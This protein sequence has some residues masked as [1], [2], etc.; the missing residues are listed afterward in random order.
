MIDALWYLV[1]HGVVFAIGTAI[2]STNAGERMVWT[3]MAITVVAGPL[4]AQ[5]SKLARKLT[6]DKHA[7][8]IELDDFRYAWL[9]STIWFGGALIAAWALADQIFFTSRIEM[10]ILALATAAMLV[11]GWFARIA[12]RKKAY[13]R[14]DVAAGVVES[15]DSTT[16]A[17]P[18]AELGTFAIETYRRPN[19]GRGHN[20]DW[21]R[22]VVP[23]F[24]KR[25]FADS[26]YPGGIQKLQARL[27]RQL[28]ELRDVSAVRRALAETPAIDQNYRAGSSVAEAV[29]AAVA[30]P[31]RRRAALTF[32]T[33]D[34]DGEIQTRA[35]ATLAA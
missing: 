18:L 6:V 29:A 27:Q 15:V 24:P 16:L 21:Y 17:V 31:A 2:A 4:L 10:S 22:L 28:D 30:D 32:L 20:P 25:V 1:F 7:F 9:W 33:R 5:F 3:G 13:L 11:A 26:V 35:R 8:R 12:G 14:V 19:I 34:P 23:G